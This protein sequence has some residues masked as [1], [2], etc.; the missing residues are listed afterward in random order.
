MAA[1]Y[2][3]VILG[4]GPGGYVCGIR[5]GQLGLKTLVVEK[6]ELGGVCLNVG[7][8]PSKALIHASKVYYKAQNGSHLGITGD[9]SV[10]LTKMVGW[11]DGIVGKLTG[12]VAGLLKANGVDHVY[13]TGK[14][15][16]PGKVVLTK[17]EGGV[18]V[19]MA[20]NVVIATGSTPVQIPFLKWSEDVISSTGALS[21]QT[22]PKRLAVVGGGVIGMELGDVYAR[23]GSEVTVI[24]AAP[25]L[26]PMFDKDMVTPLMRKQK[27][28]GVTH[29]VA[30]K[31]TGAEAI[32]GGGVKLG[33]EGKKTGEIEVDKVLVSVGRRPN[34]SDLGL[35][36]VGVQ[37][38]DLGFI[39][40]N[41][42]LQ[43]TAAGIYAIGDVA[44]NPMLAHKASKDG[45]VAAETI[46]G[47]AAA[48][49]SIIASVVYT[50]PE[51]ASVGPS[52]K[53]LKA[54]GQKLQIG[55]F[56]MSALGRAMT[57]DETL[58][59][60][61]VVGDAE[62]GDVLAIHL[63]GAEVSELVN[64]AALTMEMAAVLEDVGLTVH[65]HPT[66]SE[67][68]MEAAKAALGEAIHAVNR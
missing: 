54:S 16:G 40:T 20:K 68:L 26:L 42:Q 17:N 52:L 15:A 39:A 29:L 22:V 31:V 37:L 28:M 64:E 43:T 59:F 44:G 55:K 35:E 23:L 48:N 58:G 27:K 8:I 1:T 63:V 9:L 36:T 19:V 51:I 24:E 30:T 46:A 60:A 7:C 25:Q 18:D 56:P 66:M 2:D 50:S 21:L 6:G 14:L 57:A 61:R 67:S 65:A 12:G 10:D 33:F 34:T 45:E 62:T 3:V 41:P 47:H 53:E 13:A 49:D 11:K 32:D 5:C 38:D 4:A